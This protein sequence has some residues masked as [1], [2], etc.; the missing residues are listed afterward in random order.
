MGTLEVFNFDSDRVSAVHPSVLLI[1]MFT[2]F[3][4]DPKVV[5]WYDT[6]V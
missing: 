3:K 4:P 2:K 5:A 6:M 1:L